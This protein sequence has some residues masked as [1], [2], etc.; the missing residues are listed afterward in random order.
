MLIR[1]LSRYYDADKDTGSGGDGDP[2]GGKVKASDILNRY[3]KNEDAALRLAELYADAQN[4][5]YRLREQRRALRQ[6]RDDL[7]SRVPTDGQQLISADDAA[8]LEQY[9]AIGKKP[10]DVQA[11]LEQAST[12]VADLST[13]RR[14]TTI[15]AVAEAAGYKPSVLQALAG[16]LELAIKGTNDKPLPVVIADGKETAIADYA[17]AHWADFMPALIGVAVGAPD[18]NAGAKG[19]K[20]GPAITEDERERTARRY[21]LTF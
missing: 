13:L 15:R 12:A 4:E 16:D 10:S 20:T 6:E 9:R 7:K 21:S 8:E 5:L 3:G 14:E 1:F 17:K 2:D 11:A 18:I 19:G